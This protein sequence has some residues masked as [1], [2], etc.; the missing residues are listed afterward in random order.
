MSPAK[1]IV[2]LVACCAAVA[3]SQNNA[4]SRSDASPAQAQPARP[5][6]VRVSTGFMLGL[7]EHETMPVYPDEAMTKAIQG[8]VIFKIEV[9]ETGKITTSVPVKGDPLLVAASEDA[10]RTFHF[11]PYLLNGIPVK[12]KSEL[13]FHFT[14]KKTGNAVSGHVD[15]IASI[16]SQP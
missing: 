9:D 12:V 11:R 3:F 10:L 1:T 13:G 16:P 5:A 4:I 8:D 14:V 6:M 2:T 15:C 7:V